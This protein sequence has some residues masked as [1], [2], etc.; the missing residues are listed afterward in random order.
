M[1]GEGTGPRSRVNADDRLS[2]GPLSP[3]EGG[4]GIVEGSYVADVC[5]Q[6]TDPNP[7]DEVTQ[8]GLIGYDD[9]IDSATA[10]GPRVGRAGDSHL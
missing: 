9:E 8:L 3:V 4:N 5:P 7:L 2:L 10:R 6:P 1:S